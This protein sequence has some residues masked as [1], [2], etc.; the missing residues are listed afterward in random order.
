M[1]NLGYLLL[2]VMTVLGL[3]AIFGVLKGGHDVVNTTQHV[4]WGLWVAFYIFLLGLSAGSFLLSTLVY[5]FGVKRLE[6]VGPLALLQAILCLI[7]GGML[8]IL[9]LGHPERGL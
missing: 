8:I 1:K 3:P 2:I 9:D 7:L 5:V 6:P 4:P